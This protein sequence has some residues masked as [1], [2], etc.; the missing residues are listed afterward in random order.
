MKQVRYRAHIQNISSLWRLGEPDCAPLRQCSGET[1]C[2]HIHVSN[3]HP[4][5]LHVATKVQ[6]SLRS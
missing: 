4:E 2:I 1:C 5:L 3:V 6:K